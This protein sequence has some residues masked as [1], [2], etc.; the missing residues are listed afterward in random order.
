MKPYIYPYNL[1]SQS[2]KAIANALNTIRIRADGKFK[3]TPSALVINWGNSNVGKVNKALPH[4][5]H[6]SVVERS[7]NKLSTFKWL[8]NVGFT[9][10]PKW[11]TD[12]AIAQD[13][14]NAG[15]VVIARLK[16][17]S[18]KGQGI[19]VVQPGETLPDAPL[20]TKLFSKDKEY[21]VH[22]FKGSVI[23]FAQKKLKTGVTPKPYIR[24]HDNGWVFCREGVELPEKVSET[25]IDVVKL[26]ELDFGAVDLA[27]SKKGNVC[28]FEVNTAPGIEGTTVVNYTKAITAYLEQLKNA[29]STSFINS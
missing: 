2:A 22:V 5:N 13:W 25:A 4:L 14:L 10:I 3:H 18:S 15:S 27:I 28:V 16:L 7:I 8:A 24:S 6:P 1:D 23:D 11:S 21:R 29:P 19:Q 9:A 12:K 26:M 20:Y 17:R